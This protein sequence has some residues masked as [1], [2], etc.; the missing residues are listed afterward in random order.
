MSGRFLHDLIEDR[1][2]AVAATYALALFALVA[3]GGLAFDY[4]RLVTVD[5]EVQ[6]AA[7]EA[8][9]AAA[10]QLDQR[11]GAV[12]RAQAAV[13]SY[14]A[15]SSS[16]LVN[17]T[18]LA[19]SGQGETSAITGVTFTF[20]DGYNS[21]SDTFGSA[22]TTNADAAVVQVSINARQ[23]F[24]ALTPI[25]GALSSA[26]VTAAAV[27]GL[28]SSICKTPPMMVCA[29]TGRQ[30]PEDSDIGKGVL[31]Q[32]GSSGQ[33]QPGTFG[34]LDFGNGANAVKALLGGNEGAP[35]CV[36]GS[37]VTAQQG[38]IASAPDYLNTRFDV[39]T[40]SLTPS[41][42]ASN[43][44]NCPAASTRKDLVRLEEYLFRN[45]SS[46]APQPANPGCDPNAGKSGYVKP[47]GVNKVDVTEWA[48]VPSTVGKLEGF[49]RDDCHN[50]GTSNSVG[51]CAGG[52]FGD[53]VW[54]RTGYLDSHSSVP[55]DLTTRWEVYQWERDNPSSGL[56]PT[57]VN[58]A[59]GPVVSGCNPQGNGCDVTWKNYC[60]YPSAIKGTYHP[61]AKDRRVITVAVVDCSS[62]TGGAHEFSVK[63][64]MDVFLTEPSFARSTPYTRASQIYAEVIGPATTPGGDNAFQYYGRN[65]AVL[66]R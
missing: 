54:N 32:P 33:W 30:F 2:G 62:D 66:L 3:V 56:Q 40:S 9:I 50:T 53:G 4:A 42:C 28:Q 36:G 45:V 11:A 13:T 15:N 8:A 57:L 46:S 17:R 19:H 55:T 22:T 38:N 64:W 59:D 37:T 44:D 34:Y 49:P 65:K 12:S 52:N 6:N 1:R 41:D 63:N 31:L 47:A 51:T 20:Y 43:G 58:S 16:S 60:S 14:F 35:V 18:L 5:T 29:P 10:T 7:D 23:A 25:V 39:Y 27:A 26:D 24:F 48:Q 21:A 61:T